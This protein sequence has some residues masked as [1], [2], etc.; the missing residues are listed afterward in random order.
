MSNSYR[1]RTQ[2][3]VDKSLKVLIDQE[4]EYL[5]ILS[6]K[7]LQ[8]QLY[9]RQ[10]SDYGVVIGRISVNNG[11]GIPNAKVSIFIPLT[12]VDAQNPIISEIYPYRTISDQNEDGYRYNL[13]PYNPSYNG[14]VSTGTFFEREDVI[15]DPTLIEVYDKYYKYTTVTNESG[16]FMIFGVPVG[17]QTLFVDLDLSD[18]GE[19][20]LSPNDLIEMGATTSAMVDG[21]KFK[22]S[23][24]LNSLPQIISF[25]RNLEV[26][27]LWGEPELCSIGITRTDFDITS[28]SNIRLNPTAI[29][30]GSI[31]SDADD[32]AIKNT[33]KPDKKMGQQ[34]S[35]ITGQGKILAIRQTIGL[36]YDG[37]PALETY[38]L[39]SGGQVIDENGV[40]LVNVPMN[41]EYVTTNEFG[42]QIISTDPS[43]GVPTKGKYRFKVKWNQPPALNIPVKRGYYLLP[44]VREYGWDS[45]GNEV[46][47]AD[48]K[49]S[50]AFSVN[51]DDYGVK[52]S[53]FGKKMIDDAINCS[54]KFYEF[55][56]NKVYTV[57]NLI[58]EYR[59]GTNKKKFIGIKF[60]TDTTCESENN[61]FPI[62]DGQHQVDFLYTLYM[63][64]MI[65][66][67]PTFFALLQLLHVLKLIACILF[68]L[69]S[70][71]FLIIGG[72]IYFIGV[73]VSAIPLTGDAG[74][75]LKNSGNSIIDTAKK[76]LK[77]CTEFRFY[78]CLMTYPDCENCEKEYKV[79]TDLTP[80]DNPDTAELTASQQELGNSGVV[81]K[82]YDAGGYTCGSQPQI[83]GQA[84][85]GSPDKSQGL[86]KLN[87]PPSD[88]YLF[89]SSLTLPHR[90]NLFNTKAKYFDSL[91]TPGGGVNQIKVTFDVNLNPPA[92]KY[93]LD[94]IIC[95]AVDDTYVETFIVGDLYT[96]TDP[97]KSTD[98]NLTG[99]TTNIYSTNS[100]TGTT[101]GATTST[102]NINL[103]TRQVTY[104]N[105]DNSGTMTP[106]NSLYT[107]TASTEDITYSKYAMDIEYFQV[108]KI[109]KISLF[110]SL[111]TFS[112]SDSL[113][114][115]FINAP[116][117][118]ILIDKDG[119][120]TANS[121]PPAGCFTNF[122]DQNLVFMVRGVDP[123]TTKQK[124][125][126]DL[127]KIYGHSSFGNSSSIV[128]GD[129]YLNIPIQGK[130]R[131]VKHDSLTDSTAIDS[132][133][134]QTLFYDS[135]QYLPDGSQFSS[136][137]TTMTRYYSSLDETHNSSTPVNSTTLGGPGG[138]LKVSPNNDM[139][140]EWSFNLAPNYCEHYATTWVHNG[141]SYYPYEQ[142]EGGS[143]LSLQANIYNNFMPSPNNV[144]SLYSRIYGTLNMTVNKGTSGRQIVMRSDRLPSSTAEL[145]VNG[146]DCVLFENGNLNIYTPNGGGITTSFGPPTTTSEGNIGDLTEDADPT[147]PAM[148][149]LGTFQCADMVPLG[150]YNDENGN[151]TVREKDSKCYTTIFG[152]T[153]MENGCYIFV[154]IPIVS[155]FEEFIYL[156]E[157]YSRQTVMYGVCREVFSFL[158]QN[159]WINGTLYA[160]PFKNTTIFNT[161]SIP[162]SKYCTDVMYFNNDNGNFYYRSTP[163]SYNNQ[164]VGQPGRSKYG[165]D[166]NLMYPTTIMDLGPKQKYLEEVSITNKY[167][168]YVLN[169]ITPT[170]YQSISDLLSFFI[171][172]RLAS[173]LKIGG[174][175]AFFS[176]KEQYVDGDLAQMLSINSEIGTYP[177]E[178]GYYTG[179]DTFSYSKF[180]KGNVLGIF[181]K[182]DLQ[183]RDYITPKRK[184]Y[185]GDGPVSKADCALEKFTVFSQ[186]VPFYQ[187]EI[188][189]KNKFPETVFGTEDNTWF[190]KRFLSGGVLKHKYQELDRLESASRY[191]RTNNLSKTDYFKG[192]IYAVNSSGV[193][194]PLATNW[195]R[196]T[197]QPNIITVGAPYHFYFGLK[198]GKTAY[199]KFAQSWIDFEEITY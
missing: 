11:L 195:E 28:Q 192:Y 82:F 100:I 168:G 32:Y 17:P 99:A 110:L 65:I 147:A 116:I 31:I 92:N 145:N 63:I 156:I 15:L 35:L 70:L 140:K 7:I 199:D 59:K 158:F 44:N 157:W 155:M 9:T 164:F 61:R 101:I 120:Q 176:R 45:N 24:N 105:P 104:A 37:R 20:S 165:N 103:I 162:S 68:P 79:S 62:N 40:W 141:R 151:I 55:T 171:I 137:T 170:S 160:F 185:T 194:D 143:L 36:D 148:D 198:Q 111:S 109:E 166:R 106:S 3:G 38:N 118:T 71:I 154:R 2:P 77:L 41:L 49:R 152:S 131:N 193:L 72:I 30:M 114:S 177:F 167:G 179:L 97:T 69:I 13:L 133:S 4:F 127:S 138:G 174:I 129:F 85:A 46:S 34:C 42:Q 115:R 87:I 76:I 159:N 161:Q 121:F 150:C 134:N 175:N 80:P 132:Y 48:V 130:L 19:F 144:T 12:E 96:F 22:S 56:Y 1:I 91:V 146:S 196:N 89:S 47:S 123:N 142:V 6:L 189:K 163:Y 98:V 66:N 67:L 10:C 73:V 74:D 184:I 94:N 95:L 53:T 54:D 83:Y 188:K 180:G 191:M 78:L 136:F 128:E 108:I 5:E 187:W 23:T 33:C 90:L 113:P 39:G 27:P 16:D 84:F 50:Y 182:S 43:V 117:Y 122:N 88:T 135:Y 125:R 29:F 57:S 172:A 107:L 26:E 51:W 93:H 112:V 139:T 8:E 169:K 25:S 60:I 14:H 81:S 190:T 75:K 58:S 52:T 126:Y 173:G 197:P 86:H 181:Y 124:N 102:P 149:V 21:T 119:C 18:I 153:I 186:E 183:V 64:F 178:S